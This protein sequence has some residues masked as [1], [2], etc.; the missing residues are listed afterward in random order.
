MIGNGTILSYVGTWVTG[1]YVQTVNGLVSSVSSDLASV[2]LA[3]KNSNVDQSL[4]NIFANLGVGGQIKVSLTLQVENGLGYGSVDDVISIIRG[5]VYQESGQMPLADSIPY[6]QDAGGAQVATGQPD[7][8][9]PLG[10]SSGG[11]IAGTSND[12]SGSWSIGC[13][14]GNLTTTGFS[15]VGVL[16]LIA[17]VGLI[18]LSKAERTV[19]AA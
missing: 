14:F 17:I 7:T 19:G 16:V 6:Q 18:L 3:V 13:W 12:L 11:C 8:T 1:P 10:S 15:T 4:G 2:G 5:F 9:T